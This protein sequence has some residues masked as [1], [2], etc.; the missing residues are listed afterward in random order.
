MLE[1]LREAVPGVGAF[2]SGA[3]EGAGWTRVGDAAEADAV[4]TYFT[5]ESADEDAYF[6]TDGL[7]K[8]SRAQALLL[9]LSPVS[10]S[11][12]REIAAVATVNELRFVEA[13]IVVCDPSREHA[14][15]PDNVKCLLA[16]Y[17]DENLDAAAEVARLFAD[18]VVKAGVAGRAQLARAAWISQLSS[19]VLAAVESSS[20][21]HA[22]GEP[23]STIP[24]RDDV[25]EMANMLAAIDEGRFS[26]DY[27]VEMMMGDVVAAITSA[28][29]ADLVLPQLEAVMHLLELIAVIGGS[30]M[31]P[32]A[33]ALL[34]REEQAGAEAGLDW[35]RAEGLFEDGGLEAG[36][37]H[38]HGCG[39]AH[40]HGA[41]YGA[42]Y[43]YDEADEDGRFG[44]TGGFGGYSAN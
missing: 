39:H 25:P 40:A 37:H 16:G 21:Y 38:D 22:F 27:T 5:H 31:S 13:P 24:V 10:P 29:D 36:G 18:D 17:I 44:L 1:E 20:L 35:T 23:L 33:I 26:G 28:E 15:T 19:Q 41:D 2:V 11:F 12:S 8:R 7:I 3:L 30:D 34:Y 32:A 9:D 14:F 4:L 42:D 43:G 6:E